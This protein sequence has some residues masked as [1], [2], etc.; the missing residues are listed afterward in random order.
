MGYANLLLRT[1]TGDLPLDFV[2]SDDPPR[3]ST[4]SRTDE[5]IE[6][7]TYTAA[8]GNAPQLTWLIEI[9]GSPGAVK[10]KLGDVWQLHL[11]RPLGNDDI[12]TF[13]TSTQRVDASLAKDQA[14]QL[15]YVVPNPYIGAA[16]F[17]PA[18][19]GVSGRGDRR[20]EFRA[21]PLNATIRVY[22]VRGDLVRTLHQN[23]SNDG[24]VAWDV[25]TKDN[26][27]LAP[28]LYIFQVEAPDA[29]TH[30]GKFAVIK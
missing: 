2:F 13:Q 16:S 6:I 3:D 10:P 19:F 28:G 30:T 11:I 22:T 8:T 4:L 23:G 14:K 24:F 15:P 9:D 17:E 27:D 21:I 12:Y 5:F 1:P 18:P 25:R 26:L 29:P 7:V 20:I